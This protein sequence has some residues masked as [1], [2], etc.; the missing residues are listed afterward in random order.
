MTTS[1]RI[2]WLLAMFLCVIFPLALGYYVL[3]LAGAGGL[4]GLQRGPRSRQ[5]QSGDP[6]VQGLE[7]MTPTGKNPGQRRPRAGGGGSP[8]RSSHPRQRTS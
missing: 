5:A 8:A 3:A 7:S 6:P 4:G 1:E 2:G